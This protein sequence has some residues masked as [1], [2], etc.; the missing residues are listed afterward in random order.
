M[1]VLLHRAPGKCARGFTL[2][3]LM[4]AIA[5][6]AILLVIAVPSFTTA[7]NSNRLTS[8]ANALIGALNTARMAAVQRNAPVQFCSN[9]ATGNSSDTLGSAC[10]TSAGAVI[11]LSS[12][13]AT[14]T[15]QLQVPPSE[16]SVS[17]IQIHGTM[18]AV[19]FN[20]QGLGFAPGG[21]TP[22]SGTVVDVCSTS[23]STNNHIKIN[24]AAGGSVISTTTSSGA[25]P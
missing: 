5:V 12:P 23:L 11:A 22:F 24:M 16:L 10:G 9:S 3:E 21:S 20:G 19:R 7:I 18:A 17:S 2:V 1:H 25:C 8:T 14:T 4:V 13:G 6:A 15:T